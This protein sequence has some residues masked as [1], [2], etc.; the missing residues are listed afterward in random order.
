MLGESEFYTLTQFTI[1]DYQRAV[2]VTFEILHYANTGFL[3]HDLWVH[4]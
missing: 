2:S 1:I 4:I 3:T